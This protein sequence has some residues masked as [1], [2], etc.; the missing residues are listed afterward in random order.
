MVA[1]STDAC[2]NDRS[3]DRAA[4]SID[5]ANPSL[6]YN[7]STCTVG[8]RVDVTDTTIVSLILDTTDTTVVYRLQVDYAHDRHVCNMRQP[9]FKQLC[10]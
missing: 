5:R 1:R 9:S 4:R 10:K 3:I 2:T 8:P 6:T 7:T